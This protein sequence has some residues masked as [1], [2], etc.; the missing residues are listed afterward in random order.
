MTGSGHR[1][2]SLS[3][4][5]LA[6]LCPQTVQGQLATQAPVGSCIGLGRAKS[7]VS[8]P[9]LNPISFQRSASHVLALSPEDEMILQPS[10]PCPRCPLQ[11]TGHGWGSAGPAVDRVNARGTNH[12]ASAGSFA[13]IKQQNPRGKWKNCTHCAR[14]SSHGFRQVAQHRV[15]SGSAPTQV[16]LEL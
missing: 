3:A 1:A 6:Q 11:S 12:P 7:P 5:A 13:S 10:S 8:C 2:L 9:F 4:A 16:Q 15:R 14:R